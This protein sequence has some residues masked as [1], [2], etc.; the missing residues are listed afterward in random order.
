VSCASTHGYNVLFVQVRGRGDAYYTSSLVPGPEEY[1][2]IPDTFD[3][4]ATMIELAHKRGIE[5]HAWVNMYLTWSSKNPPVSLKHLVNAHPDWFM[6]SVDGLNMSQAPMDSILGRQTEGRYISPCLEEVRDHLSNVITELVE[7]YDIDGVHLDYIRYP[8]RS[9]DFNPR[10]RQ[11]FYTKY[12]IDPLDV[13][14]EGE[15][16]DPNFEYI[17]KWVEYK[18][19]QIDK[20]MRSIARCM[21]KK[22]KKVRLS[23]AVKPDTDEAFYEF[24][25]NWSGWLD[26]GIVDFVVTMSYFPERDYVEDVLRDSLRKVNKKKIVGGIGAYLLSPNETANQIQLMR[27]MGLLGYCIFSYTTFV[28]NRHFADTLDSLTVSCKK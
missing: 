1:P 2:Q 9:F 26:D 22:Q 13:V 12:G 27:S 16:V 6:V 11:K 25:Q 5:V 7:N 10:A 20:Q 28:E 8:G 17:K 19:E 18:N 4:L 14:M 21:M 23:A 24:G 15:K 3:P